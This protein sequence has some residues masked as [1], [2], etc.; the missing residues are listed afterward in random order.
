M[1]KPTKI[2]NAYSKGCA[3]AL[4]SLLSTSI[5]A[6]EQTSDQDASSSRAI[7]NVSESQQRAVAIEQA[8][9]PTTKLKLED[10]IR[11]N[12]EQPQVITIV[13]WQLP[14]HH[15]INESKNWQLEIGKMKPI[16]RNAFLRQLVL[17][18]QVNQKANN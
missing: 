14:V 11:G 10:T 13:P 5:L 18:K 12:K 16:E 6:N 7:D 2:R 4:L 1:V 15:K 17:S 8:S 3:L 9:I